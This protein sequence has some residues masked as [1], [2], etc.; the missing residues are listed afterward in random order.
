[1]SKEAKYQKAL[2]TIRK[3]RTGTQI[4]FMIPIILE[5]EEI[6]EGIDAADAANRFTKFLQ[7][8]KNRKRLLEQILSDYD[9]DGSY[10]INYPYKTDTFKE[11]LHKVIDS[12]Q[13]DIF[14]MKNICAYQETT[15]PEENPTL[16]IEDTE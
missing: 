2:G 1:M 10:D 8:N 4:T 5:I 15:D 3:F 7:N 16:T 9:E 6:V 13:L 11:A 12:N 14:D